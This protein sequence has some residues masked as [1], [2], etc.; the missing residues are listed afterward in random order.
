[1]LGDRRCRARRPR[2]RAR[3]ARARP[4]PCGRRQKASSS[5]AA[6]APR[7]VFT[8]LTADARAQV[9]GLHEERQPE[10][11]RDAALPAAGSRRREHA[12]L[13]LRQPRLG[14]ERLHDRLVH[15]GRGGERRRRRRTAPPASSKRPCTVPSSPKVPCST[16][17]KTSGRASS[18]AS[19]SRRSRPPSSGEGERNTGFAALGPL[20]RRRA[21]GASRRPC[22]RGAGAR[23]G[24]PTAP[25]P[26]SGPSAGSPRARRS[27]LRTREP[28]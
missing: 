20:A 8:L 9:R 23:R 4:R 27:G 7:S 25:R 6:Q 14:E 5:A 18:R 2:S 16:G 10:L 3:R 22:R 13:D 24:F 12:V 17:K 26:R 21:A 28:P 11:A 19:A 15:R 1:M